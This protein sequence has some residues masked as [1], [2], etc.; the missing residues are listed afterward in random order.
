MNIQRLTLA[1]LAT[2]AG[3]SSSIAQNPTVYHHYGAANP[4][5]EGW[6]LQTYLGPVQTG[7]VSNDMGRNAWMT[8][9]SHSLYGYSP[10]VTESLAGLSWTLSV[11]LRVVTPNTRLGVF[12]MSLATS[13]RTFGLKFGSDADGNQIVA[14]DSQTPF[15]LAGGSSYADYQLVYSAQTGTANL[16]ANGSLLSSGIMGVPSGQDSFFF[17]RGGDQGFNSHL[18]NWNL[19]SLEI[20]PEPS[21]LSLLWLGSS[22]L[23]CLCCRK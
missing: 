17:W 12:D 9:V 15:V 1:C 16:W 2:A 4:T 8:G 13:S 11:N 20:I 18:A 3:V 6:T 7:A 14:A 23:F 10:R 19:V 21:S 5:S 22:V